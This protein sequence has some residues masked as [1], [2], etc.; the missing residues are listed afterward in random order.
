IVGAV[1]G[2]RIILGAEFPSQI[3]GSVFDFYITKENSVANANGIKMGIRNPPLS[4]KM[5][6]HCS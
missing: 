6:V 4:L 2:E 5:M 3:T 1:G